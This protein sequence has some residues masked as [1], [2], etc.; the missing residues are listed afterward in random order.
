MSEPTNS[1]WKIEFPPFDLRALPRL[2]IW[3]GA[4]SGALMAAVISAYSTAGSHRAAAA[5]PRDA[6]QISAITAQLVTRAGDMENETQRLSETVQ[7]LTADRDRLLARV[8]SLERSLEDVTGSIKRQAAAVLGPPTLPLSAITPAPP[9]PQPT[10]G[11]PAAPRPP[12]EPQTARVANAPAVKAAEAE[13]TA[14]ATEFGVDVGGAVNFDGLRVLWNSTRSA[15]AAL[16]EGLHPVVVVRESKS[17]G[18][19]LRLIVG[20][21]ASTEAATR[22]C[23]AL[24]AARRFCQMT[25]F[26][27]QPFAFQM[28]EPERRAGPSPSSPRTSSKSQG[29]PIRP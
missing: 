26:E 12:A 8:A 4:A 20:P 7:A 3:G 14:A 2:A 17:R 5:A 13:A 9:A 6:A 29:R 21:L 27:G 19:D 1:T 16:F 24:L 25:T 18:V 10:V 28:N 22:T 23:A 15:N 11:E